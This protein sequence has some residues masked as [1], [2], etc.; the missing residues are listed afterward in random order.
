MRCNALK[1]EEKIYQTNYTNQK[2]FKKFFGI[3]WEFY[4]TFNVS[5]PIDKK[6]ECNIKFSTEILDNVLY[7]E[8]KFKK[9]AESLNSKKVIMTEDKIIQFKNNSFYIFNNSLK[10]KILLNLSIMR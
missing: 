7:N 10:N 9:E 3:D 2:P 4:Y 6:E 5:I 8:I 1:N